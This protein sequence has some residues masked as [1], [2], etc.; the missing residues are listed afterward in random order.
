MA[1]YRYT[2]LAIATPLFCVIT[3]VT[4]VNYGCSID[5]QDGCSCTQTHV[6]QCECRQGGLDL[7]SLPDKTQIPPDVTFLL[8]LN[9]RSVVKAR[10]HYDLLS[11]LAR[12]E[13]LNRPIFYI[14]VD[15]F[16]NTRSLKNLNI[17]FL[18]TLRFLNDFK[19]FFSNLSNIFL[20]IINNLWLNGRTQAAA[21]YAFELSLRKVGGGL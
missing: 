9:C 20:L 17:L 4:G 14:F 2:L 21:G 3:I 13:A 19:M 11:I 10:R 15:I 18:T 8:F 12:Y 7:G 1:V 16:I 5:V 6:M